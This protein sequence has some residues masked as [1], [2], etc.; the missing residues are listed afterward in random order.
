MTRAWNGSAL[1]APAAD[2]M[3]SPKPIQWISPKVPLPRRPKTSSN[4]S[5]EQVPACS[6][7]LWESTNRVQHFELFAAVPLESPSQR[8]ALGPCAEVAAQ[9]AV[10]CS[11][12]A[13]AQRRF[14][15]S[16]RPQ[17]AS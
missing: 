3:E 13:C 4:S 8:T 9:I 10:D 17:Y 7:E 6:T 15:C 1:G 2:V 11:A 16:E 12:S 14:N 5:A